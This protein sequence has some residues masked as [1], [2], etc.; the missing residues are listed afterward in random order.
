MIVRKLASEND[1]NNPANLV[2]ESPSRSPEIPDSPADGWWLLSNQRVSKLIMVKPRRKPAKGLSKRRVKASTGD[3]LGGVNLGA[4]IKPKWRKQQRKLMALRSHLQNQKGQLMKDA[5]EEDTGLQREM[6]D[7]G[8][9]SYDR[10]WALSMISS[11]QNALYE[12]EQA[13]TRMK[14]GT[15]GI[16]ELTGK[17]IPAERLEAIPWTRFTAEA[18]REL[19]KRGQSERARLGDRERVPKYSTVRSEAEEE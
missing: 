11:E 3:V 4:G 2:P 12:I 5:L 1:T 10:D 6:A 13:L 14:N 9:N 15:Y 17:R 18:E 8:T 19:E 16:C 7:V